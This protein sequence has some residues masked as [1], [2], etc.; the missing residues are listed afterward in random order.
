VAKKIQLW[1]VVLALLA[2][3]AAG[4]A[5]RRHVLDAQRPLVEGELPFTLEGAIHLHRVQQML[6]HGRLPAVDHNI[7]FP[8]GIRVRATDTVTDTYLAAGLS[9][10]LP[11]SLSLAERLRWSEVLWF[12]LGIPLLALWVWLGTRSWWGGLTAAAFYAVALAS[13]IRSTGQEL[14]H[15]NFALPL[16]L[17][18]F[19][20]TGLAARR[21]FWLNA[22]LAAVLLALALM[23]WDLIQFYIFIW[24][25]W[26]GARAVGGRLTPREQG[27]AWLQVLALVAAGVWNP[28][29]RAHGFLLSPP[30]LLAV[31]ALLAAATRR[32]FQGLGMAAQCGT[33][34][35]AVLP[36]S[37][38]GGLCHRWGR[39]TMWRKRLGALLL[40]LLPVTLGWLAAHAYGAAYGHFG[41]LLLAKLRFLNVKPDDPALLTFNQRILWVPALHSATWHLTFTLFPAIFPA[42]CVAFTCLA[43]R[44]N[45][46]HDSN[47]SLVMVCGVATFV[48]Y[49]F[50]VRLHVFV[51]LFMA[52][53]L[54][55]WVAWAVRRGGWVRAVVLAL[56]F[57][58]LTVEAVHTARRPEA[59]GRLSVYYR[60]LVGLTD[61]LRE[62]VA[63]APVLANFG[64]SAAILT[65]GD[66]P[67]LL[68]PKF[69]SPAIRARVRAYGEVLFQ[70]TEEQFRDWAEREGALYYVHALGEYGNVGIKQQMRYMVNALQPRLDAPAWLFERAP[71]Q[72]RLFTPVWSNAKYRVFRIHC[73]ADPQI[74]ADQTEAAEQALQRGQLDRAERRALEALARAPENLKAQRL[75]RT[76]LALRDQGVGVDH[77]EKE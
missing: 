49:W 76:V 31:G 17:A 35:P 56:L 45:E 55:G 20:A 10:L 12:C 1:S 64:V 16:L 66:C 11:S 58:T 36:F 23:T 8:R 34:V 9:K 72:L 74:A 40:A 67:I 28:Y 15:E 13:V 27:A 25:L 70:G 22:A 5:L 42:S 63:P 21:A 26:L 51:I 47:L 3:F 19:V 18:S 24:A 6:E 59:Q 41:E 75:L 37:Q 54:G 73:R 33:A 53:L 39:Q 71:K 60:E 46:D 2:L 14:S 4:V 32:S 57:P 29:L 62:N 52:A 48:G 50:F 69:E 61:W 30:L 68:H 65:Y 77:H 44:K 43:R 38:A 7:E